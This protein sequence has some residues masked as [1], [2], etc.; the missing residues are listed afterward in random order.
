MHF[1]ANPQNLGDHQDYPGFAV[2]N[3]EN[4]RA[5]MRI[6]GILLLALAVPLLSHA[7]NH[8]AA[9]GGAHPPTDTTFE[10]Q[11]PQDKDGTVIISIKNFQYIPAHFQVSVGTRVRWLNEEKRQFH[12]VWF[13]QLEAEAP[14]YFFPGEFYERVFDT[15]G[16]FSYH[17]SPHPQMTGLVLVIAADKQDAPP[18]LIWQEASAYCANLKQRLPS[19]EELKQLLH[20]DTS[21]LSFWSASS[22]IDTRSNPDLV[23]MLHEYGM[24]SGF[25]QKYA[26]YA[27]ANADGSAAKTAVYAVRCVE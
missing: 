11:P 9:H 20:E 16:E 12:N 6:F 8:H 2:L 7:D 13:E 21:G 10:T 1:E 22:G 5:L 23:R 3:H 14:P 25:E 27:S 19:L 4:V 15:P 26:W 18:S 17:C 24:D